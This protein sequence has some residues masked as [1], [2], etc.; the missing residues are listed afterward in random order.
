MRGW[1][2]KARAHQLRSVQMAAGVCACAMLWG[3][4]VPQTQTPPARAK[5]SPLIALPPAALG[6]NVAVQ[7]R[8]TVL[9][10]DA[11]PQTLEALLEVDAQQMQLALFH[12]GQRMGVLTWDGQQLHRDLSRWWPA[13]LPPE[14]VMSDVQLALWPAAAIRPSLPSPWFLEEIDGIRRLL[15]GREARISIQSPKTDVL[16]IQYPQGAWMLR[17]ESPGGM[18]LCPP[19]GESK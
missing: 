1:L 16:E 6:C 10:P 2:A 4:A 5:A 9:P 18:Q 17:I 8:L 11:A 12:L 3:C 15:H 19:T 14:Q 7:Q 13:Q